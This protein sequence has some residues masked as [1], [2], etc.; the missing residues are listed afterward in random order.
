MCDS[1]RQISDGDLLWEVRGTGETQSYT[2]V[3]LGRLRE[4]ASETKPLVPPSLWMALGGLP[5][6]LSELEQ[7]FEFQAAEPLTIGE[8]P[9][10]SVEGQWKPEVLA[11]LLPDQKEV[12]L[13]GGKPH[14]NQLPPQVPHGITLVLGRDR[15]IPL[16]PYSFSFYRKELLDDETGETQKTPVLTWDLFEV[17][18]RTDLMPSDFAYEPSRNEHTK[19]ER[20]DEYI[21]RLKA[22]AERMIPHSAR[23]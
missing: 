20:T 8:H 6:L 7:N 2:Y 14:W 5:R 9:V 15:V 22:E 11:R 1:L 21:A 19:E 16:F 12:I 13:S 18:I 23:R 10:W 3:N 4:V 17:R